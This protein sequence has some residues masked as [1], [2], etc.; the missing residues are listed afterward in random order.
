MLLMAAAF[1]EQLANRA[2]AKTELARENLF[3]RN[4]RRF[5]TFLQ[6][7][8]D[9]SHFFAVYR[10]DNRLALARLLDQG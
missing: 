2:A 10:N 5:V 6:N 3:H 9:L 4:F 7:R 1:R 8:T